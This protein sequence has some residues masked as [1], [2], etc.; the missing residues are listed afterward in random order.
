[1]NKEL[2]TKYAEDLLFKLSDEE[3]DTLLEEFHV[4]ESNMDMINNIDGLNKI[5]PMFYITGNEEPILRKDESTNSIDPELA[6]KNS[7][8]VNDRE[9][10]VPRVVG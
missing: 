8:K 10:E 5:E 6:F 7:G 9:V 2:L 1:M 3:L 4:V